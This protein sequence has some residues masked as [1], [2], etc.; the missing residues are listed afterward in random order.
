MVKTNDIIDLIFIAIG[1]CF[2]G[3]ELGQNL[4]VAAV[5]FAVAIKSPS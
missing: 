2:V 5:F 3:F 4:A 1:A